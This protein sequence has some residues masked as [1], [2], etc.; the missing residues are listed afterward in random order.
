MVL[1][2]VDATRRLALKDQD[3]FAEM[4]KMALEGARDE[5]ILV[6]NKVDLV[7]PKTILLEKTFQYVSL[8]NGVKHGPGGEEKSKLDTTTFMI[9]ALHNDGVIDLKNYLI[10]KAKFKNWVLPEDHPLTDW[11]MEER[12]EEMVLEKMLENC[13]EEIPYIAG[14]ACR[15][16]V[17][18]TANRVRIDVDIKVDTENQKRICIGHQGRT[19]VKIRQAA[20]QNLE[21]ILGKQVILQLWIGLRKDSNNSI[22]AAEV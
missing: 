20:V 16:I 12:V 13:H 17:P 21:G 2:V 5:I 6:L 22:E 8:I 4:V 15:S 9:S 14:I 3:I 19:L 1:I 11:T 18:L 10:S 7:H